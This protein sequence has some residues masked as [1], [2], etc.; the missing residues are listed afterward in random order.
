MRV[1]FVN[2]SDSDCYDITSVNGHVVSALLYDAAGPAISIIGDYGD[3]MGKGEWVN[4][5][6]AVASDTIDPAVTCTLTVKDPNGNVVYGYV[7]QTA[8]ALDGVDAG[9]SYRFQASMYGAYSVTFSSKDSR[10]TSTAAY[11]VNVEDRTA[12][13]IVFKAQFQT[14]ISL[15]ETI[16]VPK[17]TVSDDD[18]MKRVDVYLITNGGVVYTLHS[19]TNT[20]GQLGGYGF[21]PIYEGEYMVR[22]VVTDNNYNQTVVLKRIQVV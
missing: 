10:Q 17:F 7:G 5:P 12:P 16:V 13:S 15:G 21:K 20:S 1:Q 18:S 11:N 3:G 19:S 22:V 9:Q 6:S 4:L 8:V 2:A 14:Q